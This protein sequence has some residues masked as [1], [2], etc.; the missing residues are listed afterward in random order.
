MSRYIKLMN[1][2][3]SLMKRRADKLPTFTFTAK[4][5]TGYYSQKG[6]WVEVTSP[7]PLS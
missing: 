5:M 6:V 7:K 4:G 3:Y 1:G 2:P